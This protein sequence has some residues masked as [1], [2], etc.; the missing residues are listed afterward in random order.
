LPA[1][2]TRADLVA[3]LTAS[4]VATSTEDVAALD[5]RLFT[6]PFVLVAADN[7]SVG[8]VY[9]HDEARAALAERAEVATVVGTLVPGVWGVDVDP[10]DA[11]ADP[12]AGEAAAED[13]YAWCE[14]HGLLWWLRASGRPGGR[15]VVAAVPDMLLR[16]YRALA[17]RIAA[18]HR[19]ALTVRKPLRLLSAPHRAG[20]PAPHLAGTLRVADLPEPK[21]ERPGGTS[22]QVSTGTGRARR[23][24]L[25]GESRSEREFGD[26]CAWARA[27]WGPGRAW[28]EANQPGSKAAEQGQLDWR[29]WVWCVAV[30]VVAAEEQ[31]PEPE[32]WQRFQ[33]ASPARARQLG[34]A[35]WRATYWAAAT[36][37]AA[38]PR[39]RRRRTARATG[40]GA[41][42]RAPAQLAADEREQRI[43]SEA[44]RQVAAEQVA[45]AGRRPQFAHSLAAALDVL[46]EAIVRRDGSISL[47]AWSL[48]AHLDKHTLERARDFAAERGIIYRAHSYGA[49]AQ[50][51]DAWRAGPAAAALIEHHRETS[52]TRWDTPPAHPRGHADPTLLRPR[53]RREQQ[54][55]RLRCA[56]AR[57]AEQVGDTFA[58]SQH[59]AA[60]TLRSLWH[61]RRWWTSLTP[62]E[63]DQRRAMRRAMLGR[64]HRTER[65][66][67]FDWLDRRASIVAVAE[68][69]VASAAAAGDEQ[70]LDSAPRTVHLGLRDPLWRVG[71]T[72]QRHTGTRAAAGQQGVLVAA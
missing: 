8:T 5:A 41:P 36:V 61:Q 64:M 18:H 23:Q 50:D 34:L 25:A 29:R 40:P 69:I 45:L 26:A 62:T 30:T 68:R 33:R 66:A 54:L 7:R 3:P 24:R 6:A 55:W 32:A 43:V 31:L 19:V 1:N 16:E 22:A 14:A 60:T 35:G 39:P 57:H 20:L 71:G 28:A 42:L 63:Q 72:P 13:L 11:G 52:P 2:D 58:D 46:A 27:G 59:P 51:C 70:L 15:H 12:E 37:E 17:R 4:P 38:Q 67:W 47:R 21:A 56:L 44:L 49:S 10:G 65:S 53:Y 9:T 48:A